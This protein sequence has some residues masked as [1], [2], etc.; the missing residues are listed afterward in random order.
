M[1]L[2]LFFQSATVSDGGKSQFL[3]SIFFI[4]FNEVFK[5]GV[6]L[7]LTHSDVV[8]SAFPPLWGGGWFPWALWGAVTPSPRPCLG[9]SLWMCCR[10]SVWARPHVS[11]GGK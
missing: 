6:Y 8:F 3:M 9:S 10:D 1:S 5:R 11:R 2:S 7:L 4:I